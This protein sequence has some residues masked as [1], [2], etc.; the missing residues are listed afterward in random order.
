MN[1]LLICAVF[2]F[3]LVLVQVVKAA[4]SPRVAE[5][6]EGA[7]KEGELIFTGVEPSITGPRG[8]QTIGETFNKRYGLNLKVTHVPMGSFGRMST[9]VMQEAAAGREA[10]TDI[11]IGTDA[12]I[13]R[14]R[15][16]GALKAV[17]WRH[18]FPSVTD[19]MIA[20]DGE[21]VVVASFFPGA[22]YNTKLV[23]KPRV[24]DDVFDPKW[25]GKVGA[26]QI[27]S[28]YARIALAIGEDKMDKFV[29]RLVEYSAGIVSSGAEEKVVSGEFVMVLPAACQN[30]EPMR[31][32]GAPI[33]CAILEDIPTLSLWY[34]GV[35]KTAPHPSVASLF[36]GFLLSEEGQKVF[37]EGYGRD[38]PFV[39]GTNTYQTLQALNAKGIQVVPH[40]AQRTH[41]HGKK[42]RQLE[43]KYQKIMRGGR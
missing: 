33:D 15:G 17:A 8:F 22:F 4:S 40:D 43:E 16:V 3:T 27:F 35:P 20:F 18:Y 14:L 6:I 9:R 24:L 34:M 41:D 32:K 39:K 19:E 30:T 38:S 5:L 37:W 1:N 2:L 42:L 7:K 29:K 13:T 23:S 21:G 31:A 11:F 25:K 36:T 10:S 26:S 28:A 12:H